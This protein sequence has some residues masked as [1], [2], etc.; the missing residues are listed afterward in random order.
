MAYYAPTRQPDRKRLH[1]RKKPLL[2]TALLL[3]LAA[4][5]AGA[6]YYWQQQRLQD[7]T[8]RADGLAAQLA[9]AHKQPAASPATPTAPSGTA[10]TFVYAP[11]TGGLQLTLPTTLGVVVQVDGNKGGAPGAAFRVAAAKDAHVFTDSAY[12]GG[13]VDIDHTFTTLAA[14]LAATQSQLHDAGVTA[15]TVTDTTVAGLA[16][17][18]LACTGADEYVGKVDTYVVGAGEFTYTI[19]ANGVQ[20]GAQQPDILGAVLQGLVLEA[21]K[22]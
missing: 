8:A 7:S 6:T 18:K 9:T 20:L 11:K 5:A 1:F 16:A 2:Y 3:G 15:C 10:T 17:K 4:A 22:L 21:K 12:Q 14:A 13:E 19:T